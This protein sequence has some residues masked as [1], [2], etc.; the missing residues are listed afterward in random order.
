MNGTV[1]SVVCLLA[2]ALLTTAAC[3]PKG[4]SSEVVRTVFTVSGMHCDSCNA[5][6]A[7]TLQAT[8]GVVEASA[9]YTKGEAVAVYRPKQVSA[10]ALKAE[11]EKL[12]YAV[13]AMATTPVES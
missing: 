2:L 11:I 8:A 12:G 6:I 7:G 9:D 4:E 10:D 13:T 1:R 3:A 5:A